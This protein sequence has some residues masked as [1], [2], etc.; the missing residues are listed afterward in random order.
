[1]NSTLIH[2][3][4][5]KDWRLCSKEITIDGI[6]G[7]LVFKRD[8]ITK[9]QEIIYRCFPERVNSGNID[10]GIT[11]TESQAEAILRVDQEYDIP[12]DLADYQTLR[13]S[14]EWCKESPQVQ[15]Y[16]KKIATLHIKQTAVDTSP[17]AV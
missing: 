17:K 13:Q 4:I 15:R 10:P 11:L 9:Q 2:R 5:V 1:M 8:I 12:E 6:C 16:L 14:L 3:A 7:V